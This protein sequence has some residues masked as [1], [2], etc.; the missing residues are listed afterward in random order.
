[1]I[2]KQSFGWTIRFEIPWAFLIQSF[3]LVMG[4]SIVSGLIPARLA[5]QTPAPQVI[6]T[7]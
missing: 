4:T 6:K 2:N 7:E 3:L 5:A 1:V